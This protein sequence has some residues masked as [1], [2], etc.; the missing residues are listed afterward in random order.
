MNSVGYSDKGII[1][2]VAIAAGLV[3]DKISPYERD[4]VIFTEIQYSWPL[5]SSLLFAA[6]ICKSHNIVDFG[7][8]LGSTF[9]QN[10]KFLSRLPIKLKWKIVELEH[11]VEIGSQE[12][13]NTNLSFYRTIN[14]ASN[15]GVDIFL[16]CGSLNYVPN[17]YQ[18]LKES[19]ASK[20]QF[21]ILDRV[22]VTYKKKDI[23]AV[24]KLGKLSPHNYPLTILSNLNLQ[25]IISKEYNLIEKWEC[26]L[27]PDTKS[28][29]MGF[30][31]QRT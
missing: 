21:I 1:S 4:G 13:A 30:I 31:Y 24:Q 15:N 26:N 19:M 11:F 29:L 18:T 16:F 5:L 27:Q 23:F 28:K 2:T 20:P 25:N 3:R 14:E 22:L 8:A 12:F 17:P 7:G 9:Q 10:Y 6:N